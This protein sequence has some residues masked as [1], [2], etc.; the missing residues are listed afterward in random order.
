MLTAKG[1]AAR[2][3]RL[4]GA[5][6]QACDVL[7]V[8]DPSHLTYFAGYAPSP[9]VFRTVESGALLLMEPG[10][11]ILVADDMLGPYLEKSHADEVVAPTWYDGR[12]SA[13]HRRTQLVRTALDRLASLPGRRIG[14]E[15]GSVPSG[16]IE[17]LRESRPGLEIVDLDPVIRPMRRS[18]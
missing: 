5:L 16:V 13:P 3:E 8:G 14:V 1:C 7:V 10:R 4:W 6:P 18:K 9:F 12:H 17:G 11:A 15:R 2:R